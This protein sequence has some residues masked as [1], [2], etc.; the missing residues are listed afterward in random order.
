MQSHANMLHDET[1]LFMTIFWT[2]LSFLD[3]VGYVILPYAL[4]MHVYI[5]PLSDIYIHAHAVGN[6]QEERSKYLTCPYKTG[7]VS[8][9]VT[10]NMHEDS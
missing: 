2:L 4:F 9:L 8:V 1:Y 5:N 7:N 3:R 10:Y 6:H